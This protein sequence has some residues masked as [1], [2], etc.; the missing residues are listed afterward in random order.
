[1]RIDGVQLKIDQKGQGLTEYLILLMLISVVSI[2]AAKSLGG[3]IKEKIQ[4]ARNHI[5]KELTPG[6]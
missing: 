5:N 1:M 3:T 4:V 6:E 2:V